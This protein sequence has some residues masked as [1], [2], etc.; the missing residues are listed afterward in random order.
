MESFSTD[1]TPVE[2]L[3][4][5]MSLDNVFTEDELRA[6]AARTERE[7]RPRYL[8]ELKIDGLAVALVYRNG[9]LERAA[10][11]GDGRMGE[12][13]TPNVRTVRNVPQRLAGTGCPPVLEVRGE[14]FIATADFE[15][16]QRAARRRGQGAVGQPAQR[17]GRGA[18]AR[19]TPGS[20]RPTADP[21]PARD[22]RPRGLGACLAV[23]GLPAARAWGLPVSSRYRGL[24]RHR[25]RARLR[26]PLGR[27][28][29]R[30]RARD[31][32]GRRE[33]RPGRPAAP[34]RRDLEG[35]ALG[36]RAQVPAGGGHDQAQRHRGQHRPHRP[37]DA[38]RR[39]RA[40][41]R[42]RRHGRHGHA[43]QR[44][45]G[46]PQGRPHRRHGLR[47]AGR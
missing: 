4:R 42:R 33:G 46:R 39:P 10:T 27:A 15:R 13:I 21:D 29:A 9:V 28:P 35:T 5:L 41:A 31:R 19:R 14:V 18:C 23:G 16:P 26:R 45:R 40:G 17:R 20:P 44:A 47:T 7:G 3:E 22:R 12:D 32:R 24:R 6:W 34:A 43:A 38:V 11:R 36:D 2:H 37:G 8:C 1:F 30:R 25:W